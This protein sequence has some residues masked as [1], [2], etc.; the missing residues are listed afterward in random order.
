MFKLCINIM[1]V[2]LIKDVRSWGNSAGVLLPREW[3]GNRVKIILIERTLEI[4]KEIFKILEPCLSKVIGVYI[5]GSYAREEQ[6]KRSDVDVIVI[7]TDLSK[8]I[9]SG[10]YD[11]SIIPLKDIKKTIKNKSR[12]L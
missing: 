12:A 5:A 11:I 10:K 8:K 4:K 7:S 3:K 9:I 2:E 1:S 6:T